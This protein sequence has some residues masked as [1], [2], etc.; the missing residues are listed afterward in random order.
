MLSCKGLVCPLPSDGNDSAQQQQERD[1]QTVTAGDP[2]K[3]KY[4]RSYEEVT[5]EDFA[6]LEKGHPYG[7]LPGGNRFLSNV[8][9]AS[10]KN[11]PSDL[12]PD[13][14]CWNT[15]LGFC[16]ACDLARVASACR[17]FYVVGH[18]PELWRDLVLRRCKATESLISQAGPT[19]KDT[20]VR[21][22]HADKFMG[23]HRP[24]R[25][26]GVY[27]EYFYR[28]H[29]CRSFTIPQ[30][31]LEGTTR[32]QSNTV[33]SVPF[34]SLSE[35][36]FKEKYEKTNTP[37]LIKGAAQNWK[38]TARWKDRDYCLKHANGRTFHTTSGAAA[39]PGYF[40]L[41]AYFHYCASSILEEAPL[42]LFDRSGLTPGSELWNDYM[43]D[44]QTNC[45]YWD[46]ERVSENGHD[47]F[48]L[49][50]EGRRPDHTW[51]IAGPLRSG[52]VFHI[53]PNAT[54]AWNATICG[55]KRWIFYP[56]GVTPPGVHPSKDGDEV[57]LPLSVG[58]WIFNFWDAHVD[59]MK[60]ALPGECPLECTAMPGDILF[61]PHG[62]WH[63]VVN[64]DDLN[65]AVTHNYVSDS[66]L[67]NMMKFLFSKRDQISGCRDRSES[68]KPEHLYD[69]FKSVMESRFPNWLQMALEESKWTCRA[70]G[71]E[72][73]S[74]EQ[75]KEKK[76]N[77]M[78]QAKSDSSD[79]SFSFL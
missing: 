57:T 19:W 67:S 27:S 56:P 25:V 16:D 33:I 73:E 29:S 28:L 1:V 75:S 22:F 7:A 34:E 68:I 42:Y 64:L 76:L 61:V 41:D 30:S 24:M 46:P 18:Q 74:G 77:V 35:S 49:L 59:M 78:D 40:T 11:T 3:K 31:W 23:P 39:L 17:F 72:T 62:W 2:P 79:F 60:T 45:P 38:A 58:E 51:L 15:I 12:I 13:D 6:E 4:R 8:T 71:G 43:R 5:S 66:N 65:I 14:E 26:S 53:D 32:G 9:T 44:L 20:Y 37:V 48:Q 36:D 47:L 50:G 63:M 70:W 54:H 55:R 21:L 52:S 10:G 69:E